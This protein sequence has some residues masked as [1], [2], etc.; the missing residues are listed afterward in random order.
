[1]IV[2]NLRLAAKNGCVLKEKQTQDKVNTA[3]CAF[4]FLII[5]LISQNNGQVSQG[6]EEGL[7]WSGLC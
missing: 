6:G 3:D 1:M 4:I 5:L 2:L 7:A